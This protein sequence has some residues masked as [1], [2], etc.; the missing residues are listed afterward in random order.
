M[1]LFDVV[2]LT[3]DLPAEGLRSGMTGTIVYEHHDP[4]AYEVEF[5]DEDGKT[6]AMLALR[7][8]QLRAT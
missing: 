4:P 7:P 1:K 2:T 8:D 3:E 5:T 6:I